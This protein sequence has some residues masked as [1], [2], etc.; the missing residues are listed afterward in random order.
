M[1]III[2]RKYMCSTY[3]V[4]DSFIT[5]V[6]MNNIEIVVLILL[7]VSFKSRKLPENY[8]SDMAMLSDP[9]KNFKKVNKLSLFNTNFLIFTLY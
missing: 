6:N 1:S 7:L 4:Y 8:W 2:Y 5:S 3:D 9:P